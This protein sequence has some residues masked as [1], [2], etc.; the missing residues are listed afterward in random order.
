MSFSRLLNDEE[1][2]FLKLRLS[3]Q[4]VRLTSCLA[5][6]S[7]Q[8]TR[9][10]LIS[11]LRA[12]IRFDIGRWTSCNVVIV[13]YWGWAAEQFHI[14]F[15]WV[16]EKKWD[17]HFACNTCGANTK[18]FKL[19]ECVVLWTFTQYLVKTDYVFLQKNNCTILYTSVWFLAKFPP[20]SVLLTLQWWRKNLSVVFDSNLSFDSRVN[21]FSLVFIK[22]G[23]Q[24]R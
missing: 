18:N 17:T 5:G 20:S 7:Q 13:I 24:L 8:R 14:C 2:V 10:A 1:I 16:G 12:V 23:V 19:Q 21:L 9:S 4:K 6:S 11:K 15:H 3:S 22:L